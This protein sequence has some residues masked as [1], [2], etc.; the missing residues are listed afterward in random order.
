MNITARMYMYTVECTTSLLARS[1][2]SSVTINDHSIYYVRTLM[3]KYNVCALAF[4]SA[5]CI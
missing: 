4:L 3:A 2:V 1:A 5:M